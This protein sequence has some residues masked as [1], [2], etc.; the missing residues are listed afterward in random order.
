MSFNEFVYEQGIVGIMLGTISGLAI[1]NFIKD[2]KNEVIVKLI[3]KVHIF[4]NIILLASFIEL[5]IMILVIYII[6]YYVLYPI[7]NKEIKKENLNKKNENKW[8]N[9]LLYEIKNID[10]G[11]VYM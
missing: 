5:L 2:L 3:K 6:Y 8:K 10:M 4:N 9:D 7:F 1:S 11:T